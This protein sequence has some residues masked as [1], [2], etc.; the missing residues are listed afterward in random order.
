[1]G[2]FFIKGRQ[3][4]GPGQHQQTQ[5]TLAAIGCNQADAITGRRVSAQRFKRTAELFTVVFYGLRIFGCKT[6]QLC[7]TR[8]EC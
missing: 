2:L 1:M 4:Y 8:R 5:Q 7:A 6:T 3:P